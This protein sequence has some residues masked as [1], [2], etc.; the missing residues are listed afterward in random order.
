MK[1]AVQAALS[2]A[3]VVCSLNSASRARSAARISPSSGK[4]LCLALMPLDF[5]RAGV[6]VAA[7]RKANVDDS[8]SAYCVYESRVGRVEFDIFYPAGESA[9]AAIGTEKTVEGETG[10]RFEKVRVAGADS[11]SINLAVPG[12]RP[13]ASM[14]VRRKTAVF[15]IDIPF[16]SNA[17]EQ[18]EKLS[19]TVLQRLD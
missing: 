13:S 16:H 19:Q 18:L 15:A 1:L 4:Q 3:L 7:L 5:T 11:A 10:G 14:I 2:L 12:R 17:R 6:P 9:E 8:A